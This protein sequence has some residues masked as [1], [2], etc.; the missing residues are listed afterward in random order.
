[1][2]SAQFWI[3]AL[4]LLML[5][6]TGGASR[7]DVES[8]VILRPLSVIT[9]A[10]SLMTLRRAHLEGRGLLL[11]WAGAI[12][13]LTLLHLLPLPPVIWQSLA[14]REDLVDVEK[15]SGLSNIWRPLT[16]APM[17]G[18]DTFISLF[19]PL[20]VV[21][22]GVQ[23]TR[24]ELFGLLPLVIGLAAIS[25][26]VG[27][28]QVTGD[29]KSSLYFYAITNNGS[30]VGLF[31]NRNHSATLL[32]LLFPMLTIFASSANDQAD[33]NPVRRLLVPAFAIVLVPLI[34][35]T[36]SRS[37]LASSV[38]G[39]IA[40]A[41]LYRQPND[42]HNRRGQ[43]P[44]RFKTFAILV[45]VGILSIG[46]LTYFLARAEAI[47]R[48]FMK[49]SEVDNRRDFWTVS[50]DLLGKYFPWGSGSGS[51]GDAYR[52]LEPTRFLDWTYLNHAHNDWVETAVTLGLPGV[53]I[54][55]AVLLGFGFRSY[56]LWRGAN[57][58]TH[59]VAF[60][61]LASVIMAMLAIASITDYPLRTPTMIGIFALSALWF[62][63]AK[64]NR[65]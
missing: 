41:M 11:G 49:S 14:G 7:T 61:R 53:I 17:N 21:L 64:R 1:M 37:G 46:L 3:L 51:F 27:L 33:A 20:T 43:K 16:Q 26:L 13:L 15:I 47:E 8:L 48:L 10:L 45:G 31:A 18:W 24:N 5:F 22:L 29:P 23:L 9:C 34:L 54:V 58:T 39:L 42:T 56:R 52:V 40:A 19:V 57:N 62:V 32:A 59:A 65:C 28:L 38:V 6:A 2:P 50:V 60:G 35:V 36:G 30:A 44:E 4:F 55:L 12:F 25:G 63:E